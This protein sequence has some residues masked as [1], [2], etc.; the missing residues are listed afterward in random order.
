MPEFNVFTPVYLQG[1]ACRENAS[2]AQHRYLQRRRC[3]VAK[4]GISSSSM[5][6]PSR[7]CVCFC[8]EI[9]LRCS[10]R[11]GALFAPRQWCEIAGFGMLLLVCFESCIFVEYPL[12]ERPYDVTH[13]TA[14]HVP[15]I[16][17]EIAREIGPKPNRDLLIRFFV[18][19]F[20]DR[21]F[22]V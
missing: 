10:V 20:N 19:W 21:C 14:V 17:S 13:G 6:T 1:V 7:I 2:G 9:S 3:R 16:G 4:R 5:G 8:I 22:H 18:F 12:E 11:Y 15:S